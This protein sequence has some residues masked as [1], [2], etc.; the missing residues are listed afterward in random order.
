[1]GGEFETKAAQWRKPDLGPLPQPFKAIIARRMDGML[2]YRLA[3]FPA[4]MKIAA[5]RSERSQRASAART[6][7]RYILHRGGSRLHALAKRS[8]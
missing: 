5:K 6:P 8:E 2:G 4:P 7:K 3:P 1:M